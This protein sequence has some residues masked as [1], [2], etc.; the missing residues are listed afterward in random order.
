MEWTW[1]GGVRMA[2]KKGLRELLPWYLNGTLSEAERLAVEEYIH[3]DPDG[4]L[5]L[6]EWSQVRNFV[7]DQ[8]IDNPPENLDEIIISRISKQSDEQLKLLHPY[9]IGLAFVILILLWMILRPGVVLRWSITGENVSSFRV[10][11][12]ELGSGHYQLLDEVPALPSNS[13]Y[14][15]V[16]IFILPFKD[17]QYYVEGV[18]QNESLGISQAVTG[19][20]KAALPGQIAL[21]C[22]SFIIGYGIIFLIRNSRILLLEYNRK[23]PG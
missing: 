23:I 9:A 12:S 21:V 8:V 20:A 5:A 6:E 15:Y 4:Q 2:A 19:Y 14:A 16:D 10:F 13:K 1:G 22:A 18:N 17:Y 7:Q 3:N 11:R